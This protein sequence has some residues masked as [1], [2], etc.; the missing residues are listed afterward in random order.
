MDH[1]C[2]WLNN[3]IGFRNYHVFMLM[4][5][6]GSVGAMFLVITLG[7]QL[8]YDAVNALIV[9]AFMIGVLSGFFFFHIFLISKNMTVIEHNNRLRRARVATATPVS[10]TSPFLLSPMMA[11]FKA[12][13]GPKPWLWLVP[14]SYVPESRAGLYFPRISH[15]VSDNCSA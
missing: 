14:F 13:L 3:C 15:E 11:N 4:L 6:Y 9:D 2:V 8:I 1:H 7:Q 12:A 5:W 10:K